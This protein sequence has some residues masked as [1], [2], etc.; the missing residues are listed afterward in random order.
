MPILVVY[1]FGVVDTLIHR[2]E[3]NRLLCRRLNVW[4][5]RRRLN[6]AKEEPITFFGVCFL[7]G[8]LNGQLENISHYSSMSYTVYI[9]QL[10]NHPKKVWT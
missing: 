4:D 6:D 1:L 7:I 3:R 10:F 9:S 5:V 2:L 8:G